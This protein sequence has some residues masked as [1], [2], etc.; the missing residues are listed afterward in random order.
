M[1]L[2]VIHSDT[3]TEK[4]KDW[5]SKLQ[6]LLLSICFISL[7]KIFFKDCEIF[8]SGIVLNRCNGQGVTNLKDHEIIDLFYNALIF[9]EINES[10][11]FSGHLARYKAQYVFLAEK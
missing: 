1:Y 6:I 2:D 3:T 9:S 4:K 10:A 11:G 5:G 8:A 7:D